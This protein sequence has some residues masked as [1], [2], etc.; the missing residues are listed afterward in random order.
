MALEIDNQYIDSLAPNAAAAKNGRSLLQKK[1]LVALYRTADE[2]LIFGECAGSG[3]SNYECSVDFVQQDKPVSRC[4]CPS[5]Q[6]PCKHALAL[7]YAYVAGETFTEAPLPD[8]IASK[9]EKMEKREE[10]KEERQ[11]VTPAE[12]KRKKTA[13]QTALKKKIK[14]QL[15][16]LDLLEKFTL[17]LIRSGLGT[18]D[19]K[20]VKTINEHVKQMGNYYLTGAQNELRRLALLMADKSDPEQRYTAEVEQLCR[21]QALVQK[22]RTHL[23]ARLEDSELALDT[24]SAIEEWLGHTWQLAELEQY[25]RKQADGELVQLA[26]VSYD[27]AGRQEF[28]DLGY[29]IEPG[30]DTIWRTFHYRPYRAVKHL[31]EEDSYT[32]SVQPMEWYRYPGD[33]N[34]RIRWENGVLHPLR[35]DQLVSIRQHAKR[36]YTDVIKTVKNQLKNPLANTHPALLLHVKSTWK[37]DNGELYITDEQD[38]QIVLGDVRE[39]GLPIPATTTLL[40]YVEQHHLQDAVWLGLFEHRVD[41]GQLVFQP[42]SIVGEHEIIRLLY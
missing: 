3:K 23:Q 21:I 42:L 35:P 13:S 18:V 9:R 37:G 6:F 22:G 27:D 40:A 24:E 25:G 2:T 4:T 32:G 28:V 16:G 15:D 26:F 7:M 1:K 41:T 19:T 14:A 10:K 11:Q 20:V 33:L 12:S 39:Q 34:P 29:W 31:R 36:D 17:T 5:R 8:E 38:Q 30:K